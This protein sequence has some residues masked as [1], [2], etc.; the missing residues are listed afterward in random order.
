[1][2]VMF[3]LLSQKKIWKRIFLHI[4][5]QCRV[6][7]LTLAAISWNSFV[8][9]WLNRHVIH[10]YKMSLL[11]SL[12]QEQKLLWNF[13]FFNW[14]YFL[15]KRILSIW[16]FLKFRLWRDQWVESC[17]KGMAYFSKSPIDG[18]FKECFATFLL[19]TLMFSW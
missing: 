3:S 1:M 19:L 8:C 5:L 14:K 10:L 18:L 7:R 11:Q 13:F 4:L 2:I 15:L 12:M 16:P 6:T 17:L 9:R